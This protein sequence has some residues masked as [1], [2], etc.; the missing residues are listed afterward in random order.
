MTEATTRTGTLRR[1]FKPGARRRT[2]LLAA[3][4]AGN[5]GRHLPALPRPHPHRVRQLP[6]RP[7]RPPGA[8]ARRPGGAHR[9][10]RPRRPPSRGVLSGRVHSRARPGAAGDAHRAAS[11]GGAARRAHVRPRRVEPRARRHQPGGPAARARRRLL[12]V[13][14][15]GELRPPA[16][17]LPRRARRQGVPVGP[18]AASRRAGDG[19]P[20]PPRRPPDVRD[21]R[22]LPR[23]LR[24]AGPGQA[25]RPDHRPPHQR[26]RPLQ[27][28]PRPRRRHHRGARRAA[29]GTS[30]RSRATTSG[31]SSCRRSSRISWSSCPTA[32]SPGDVPGTRSR[33]SGSGT[34]RC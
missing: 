10:P 7:A 8:G 11:R 19:R 9:V 32:A 6:G 31:S 16:Q 14:G 20:L 18:G 27:R 13:R 5:R 26:A 34:S 24:R 30:F 28:E 22:R 23:L 4:A 17:L 3:L 12:P 33:G 1:L 21:R 15:H 29:S 25:G 2:I